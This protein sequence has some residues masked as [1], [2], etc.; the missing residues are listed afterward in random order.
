MITL[1]EKINKKY[2][3]FIKEAMKSYF[4]TPDISF[5]ESYSNITQA[6]NYIESNIEVEKRMLQL[7]KP[8][9]YM[10]C[11]YEV[12]IQQGTATY[13]DLRDI[14]NSFY[15]DADHEEEEISKSN[16]S[17]QFKR[18]F[19]V[20]KMFNLITHEMVTGTKGPQNFYIAP[21][22]TEDQYNTATKNFKKCKDY[23]EFYQTIVYRHISDKTPKPKKTV[24][25]I[26]EEAITKTVTKKVTKN[27]ELAMEETIHCCGFSF[28]S[29]QE[30]KKHWDS[31]WK[32]FNPHTDVK[33]AQ[34]PG[35]Q[36]DPT[37]PLTIKL[38]RKCG[39]SYDTCI[40]NCEKEY[41][42][43]KQLQTKQVELGLQLS[44]SATT[45][46]TGGND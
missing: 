41:F 31:K 42:T 37:D 46:L 23:F 1:D 36:P 4:H 9:R 33:L 35:Y 26:T 11:I 29:L 20:L 22:C 14:F 10:K 40:H 6:A 8:D 27:V 3:P 15:L 21:F 45:L 34:N 32:Y 30:A 13:P 2:F 16:A 18:R 38:C 19:T 43:K 17:N 28:K 44:E 25:D 39:L 7:V 5:I 12:L 24:Q